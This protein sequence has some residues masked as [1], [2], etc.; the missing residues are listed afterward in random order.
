MHANWFFPP[1]AYR[2]TNTVN[3]NFNKSGNSTMY[4]TPGF[5]PSEKIPC[6]RYNVW[7]R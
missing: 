7:Q 4:V 3:F 1:L 6:G 5:L 2:N